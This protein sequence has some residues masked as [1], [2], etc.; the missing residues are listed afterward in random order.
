MGLLGGS[1]GLSSSSDVTDSGESL[2]RGGWAD[3][4]SSASGYWLSLVLIR[5]TCSAVAALSSAARLW[6]SSPSASRSFLDRIRIWSSSLFSRW[7]D[8]FGNSYGP[9]DNF[10]NR[11]WRPPYREVGRLFDN[12]LI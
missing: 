2:A 3:L 10:D 5:F 8:T 7:E 6:K 4:L 12:W 11:P 9:T 1:T